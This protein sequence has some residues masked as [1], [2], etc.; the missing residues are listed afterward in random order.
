MKRHPQAPSVVAGFLALSLVNASCTDTDLA[1]RI[2][3][4]DADGA[5]TGL[6]Y[7]D[8]NGNR[9]LLYRSD[10]GAHRAPGAFNALHCRCRDG[11]I[12][13]LGKDGLLRRI[14]IDGAP[15]ARP[16]P[17]HPSESAG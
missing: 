9:L 1:G 5:I 7:L 16:A 12:L 3:L 13:L 15:R 11:Q 6:V 17:R 2:L 8:R 4:V 14:R 10:E